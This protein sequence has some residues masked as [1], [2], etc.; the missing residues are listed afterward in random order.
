ML[1]GYGIIYT[2]FSAK[3]SIVAVFFS[4]LCWYN[5]GRELAQN[6]LEQFFQ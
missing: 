3:L 2:K 5:L 4:Y 1:L 6:V